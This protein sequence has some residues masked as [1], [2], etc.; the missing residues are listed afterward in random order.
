MA[1]DYYAEA[2]DIA[3][4]LDQA[5]LKNEAQCLR[6]AIDN[7]STA[8]EI[9]MALRW[10]LKRVDQANLIISLEVRD[11]IRHLAAELASVLGP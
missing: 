8:T 2:R 7:G 3:R 5:N 10:Q 6:D 1:P 4:S 11:R 9:L